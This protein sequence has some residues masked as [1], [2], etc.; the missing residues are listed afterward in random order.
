VSIPTV[1]VER[2]LLERVGHFNEDPALN[3]RED[4][5]LV[6]RLAATAPTSV[7]DEALVL[8]RDHAGRST[9]TATDPFDRTAH[10]YRLFVESCADP[11]LNRIARR[12]RAYCLAEAGAQ[13]LRRGERRGAGQY[14]IAALRGGDSLRHWLSALRRGLMGALGNTVRGRVDAVAV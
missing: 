10:A 9:R 12:R 3:L 14:Y 1:M 6:L 13:R 4:Y 11:E 2:A 8:V 5:E 7:V